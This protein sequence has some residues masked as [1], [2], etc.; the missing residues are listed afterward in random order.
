MLAGCSALLSPRHRLRT[1]SG[2][3][4][5]SIQTQQKQSCHFQIQDKLYVSQ[6]S[7]NSMSTQRLDLPCSFSRKEVPRSQPLIESSTTCSLRRNARIPAPI[8]SGFR[9]KAADYNK[10]E[11]S[12]TFWE[13]GKSLK[14]F[15]D[16]NPA[17]DF[18]TSRAKRIRGEEK[19]SLS[20]LGH[21]DFCFSENVKPESIGLSPGF[22]SFDP[23]VSFSPPSIEEEGVYSYTK[24]E[25]ILSPLPLAKTSA[26]VESI[27]TEVLEKGDNKDGETSE[28][29]KKSKTSSS[30]S[31]T[32]SLTHKEENKSPEKDTGEGTSVPYQPEEAPES[33]ENLEREQGLELVSLLVSCTEAI[34]SKNFTLI[35]QFL[36]RLGELASP[37]GTSIHR[38]VAYFTEALTLRVFKLWPHIFHLFPLQSDFSEDDSAIGFRLL[39]QMNPIP[40]FMHFTANEMI[41]R[42]FEGK[43]QVHIIDFD[44][45]QG[46]QWPGLFQSLATRPNPPSHVRITGIGESK[47]ELQETG[48]RLAGFA[49]A[50]NLKF[51][52]HAVVDKLED[53][54][55]WM[56]HVKEGESV[57]VNCILQLHTVLYDDNVGALRDLLGLMQSTRPVMVV[58]AEQEASHNDPNWE[59]RFLRTLK[60]YSAIFDSIDASFPRDS[61][62]RIKVEEM[63]AREIRNIVACE[64]RERTERHESFETWKR[65]M[66]EVGFRSLRVEERERLQSQMIL[67]MYDC[68][69]YNVVKQGEEGLTLCWLDQPLFT[70]SSWAPIDVAGSSSSFSQPGGE[71]EG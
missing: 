33:S 12:E 71:I 48:E 44:I 60:Y 13:R 37:E 45:K 47:H 32:E 55:L 64:G 43:D 17:E 7:S 4:F 38:V 65:L 63:F 15:C 18:S 28:E 8:T 53:V 11:V 36:S 51:E 3:Q 29:P 25:S 46:L 61:P 69:S 39:N 42:A 2:E 9:P 70:V 56:L 21:D 27:V 68:D 14:R 31:E 59:L 16:Q 26:W 62:A 22:E 52:F 41:L 20:Q 24:P 34:T 49:E 40:K 35:S 1:D 50:M 19:L 30:S 66:E 58:I 10:I 54:R 67:K 23:P 5:H 6:H 57:V